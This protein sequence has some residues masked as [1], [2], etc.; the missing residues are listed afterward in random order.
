MSRQKNLRKPSQEQTRYVDLKV[1]GPFYFFLS[2]LFHP[3]FPLSFSFLLPNRVAM[4]RQRPKS[5]SD[6]IPRTSR[7]LLAVDGLLPR[8]RDKSQR[9]HR[10]LRMADQRKIGVPLTSIQPSL[11]TGTLPLNS[12]LRRCVI[13]GMT[14]CLEVLCR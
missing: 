5:G 11:K 4:S 14:T 3:F 8:N 1:N 9:K 2:S 10:R 7:K 13:D 12:G 6:Q